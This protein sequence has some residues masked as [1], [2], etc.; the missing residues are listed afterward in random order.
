MP[1][2]TGISRQKLREELVK[3]GWFPE[4]KLLADGKPA[5]AGFTDENNALTAL[6]I[7]K[8]LA[9]NRDAAWSL[10]GTAFGSFG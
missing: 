7:R 3:R 2:V 6:K 4:G 1:S 5:K 10:K 8:L 9:F